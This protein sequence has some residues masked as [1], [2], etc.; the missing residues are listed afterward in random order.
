MCVAFVHTLGQE[1]KVKCSFQ[2]PAQA[3]VVSSVVADLLHGGQVGKDDI[4]VLTWYKAQ[5]ELLE[6]YRCLKGCTIANVDGFQ[7]SEREV[8]VLSTV[9]S[10]T[11]GDIGFGKDGKRLNVALTRAKRGLIVVG[12]YHTL[13]AGDDEGLWTEWFANIPIMNAAGQIVRVDELKKKP[14]DQRL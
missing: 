1:S 4:G 9:R 13:S 6:T 10:N 14:L 12:N 7:G 3:D 8:M 5:Q 2:N 11:R